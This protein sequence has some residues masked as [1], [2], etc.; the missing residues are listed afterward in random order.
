MM[1]KRNCTNTMIMWDA[2]T[3]DVRLVPWPMKYDLPELRGYSSGLAAYA[4]CRCA[5]FEQRKAMLFIEFAH[6]TVRDGIDPLKLHEVLLE[7]E[8]WRSG[9]AYD[10]PGADKAAMAHGE[11]I[12]PSFF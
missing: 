4:E 9:C 8:E 11:I 2:G 3:G 6:I 1:T 5:T 7:L 12:D 10:M